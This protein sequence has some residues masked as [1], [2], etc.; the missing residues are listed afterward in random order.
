MANLDEL[1][2]RRGI[3]RAAVKEAKDALNTIRADLK[4]LKSDYKMTKQAL[5]EAKDELRSLNAR[6]KAEKVAVVAAA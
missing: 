6:I 4:A 5:R 2:A 1:K 3:V